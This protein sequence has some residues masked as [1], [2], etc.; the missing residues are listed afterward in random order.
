MRQLRSC[1]AVPGRHSERPGDAPS[2]LT[3]LPDVRLLRPRPPARR[4][5]GVGLLPLSLV[6]HV[7][8]ASLVI[9]LC[10]RLSLWKGSVTM[11]PTWQDRPRPRG[12]SA[13]ASQEQGSKVQSR[14]L[15]A[16]SSD[17]QRGMGSAQ[18]T[19][20]EA[21]AEQVTTPGATTHLHEKGRSAQTGTAREPDS[22]G[23]LRRA[24]TWAQSRPRCH[25]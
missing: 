3:V 15:T 14:L 20:Q 19:Q 21:P 11:A 6:S 8:R 9:A 22:M 17:T 25:S 1:N 7:T 2:L 16:V 24:L 18:V 13:Q 12:H 23:R 5:A 4:V 10:L